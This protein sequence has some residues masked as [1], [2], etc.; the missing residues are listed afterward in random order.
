MSAVPSSEGEKMR[1]L[2]VGVLVLAGCCPKFSFLHDGTNFMDVHSLV[3]IRCYNGDSM[4]SGTAC[5]V[6]VEESTGR[7]YV[8]WDSPHIRHIVVEPHAPRDKK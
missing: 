3:E 6:S 2:I 8:D 7:I 1:F 5:R 4:K